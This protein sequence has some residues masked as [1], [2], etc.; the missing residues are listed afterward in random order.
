[1][2][3]VERQG[4]AGAVILGLEIEHSPAE[5]RGQLGHVHHQMGA[6]RPAHQAAV[7]P[8]AVLH[9]VDPG[10]GG[11]DHD[12][13]RHRQAFAGQPVG[14]RHAPAG[15]R[16]GREIGYRQ[17]LRAIGLGIGD[18]F[19]DQP[20]GVGD[21]R[22][23]VF[24][25]RLRVGRERRHLGAG[26]RGRQHAV[27]R[28]RLVRAAE[29]VVEHQAQ[30]DRNRPLAPGRPREFQETRDRPDGPPEP[31]PQRHPDRLRVNHVAGILEQEVTFDQGFADEGGL[32]RFEIPQAAV[33]QA[34]GGGAGAGGEIARLDQ[35][36]GDALGGEVAKG[37]DPV[38]AAA[39]DEH[40]GHVTRPDTVEHFGSGAH[41]PLHGSG[42]TGAPVG[43]E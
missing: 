4:Q 3:L 34:G 38:D 23:V 26:L 39:D 10:A 7:E 9:L 27:V 25:D 24:R 8:E 31:R 36:G 12:P 17:C 41:S 1:M 13:G 2:R 18:Q 43:A 28:H 11:V 15:L 20:L 33:D 22:V 6:P 40:I 42:A 14:Q 35:K 37:S 21:A 30:L 5:R 16:V 29:H 32:A 19:Q